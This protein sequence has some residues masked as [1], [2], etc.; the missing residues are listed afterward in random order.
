MAALLC[1]L[2]QQCTHCPHLL[3][4]LH[5]QKVH[6]SQYNSARGGQGI[7]RLIPH[8][9]GDLAVEHS[10]F[11][12]EVDLPISRSPF[13]TL[14]RSYLIFVDIY[15]TILAQYHFSSVLRYSLHSSCLEC[16]FP[17]PWNLWVWSG[18][19]H[20]ALLWF[21]WTPKNELC[22]FCHRLSH[23]KGHSNW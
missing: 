8:W 3:S 15:F 2:L 23:E 21:A 5:H 10:F 18:C 11:R 22:R 19:N 7:N 1:L 4:W 12:A 16:Y 6:Q 13:S 9:K 14:R 20:S 17:I